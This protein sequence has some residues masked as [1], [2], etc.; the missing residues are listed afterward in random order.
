[1]PSP[2]TLVDI[3]QNGRTIPALAS[4]GKTGYMFILNRETGKPIFGV[5]GDRAEATCQAVVFAD[6]TVSGKPQGAHV[7]SST[8]TATAVR[9]EA[10]RLST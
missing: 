2:P 7:S 4:V 1:M 8:R 6:A 9:P 3:R 10:R 5:E